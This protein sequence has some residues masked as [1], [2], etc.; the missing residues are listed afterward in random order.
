MSDGG[1]ALQTPPGVTLTSGNSF[2]AW[3][4][5]RAVEAVC[6]SRGFALATSRVAVVGAAGAIGHALTLL[7]SERIGQMILI[8]NPRAGE[9]SI[10]NLRAV[11]QDCERHVTSLSGKKGKFPTGILAQ[12]LIRRESAG[13][14][15]GSDPDPAM[16]VT[17]DLDQYLPTA[18]IIFTATS[19]VLP[20]I[21]SRHLRKDAI[22]CDVSR[23][24]NIASDLAQERPD[25]A[26]VLGGLVQAPKNSLLGLLEERDRPNI[27]MACA[28]ET[29]VLALSRYRSNHLCGRLDLA[30][31]EEM[32]RLAGRMGFSVAA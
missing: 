21:S 7:C 31:I 22:V 10:G 8:G 11:V 1:L 5:M 20:F 23:P 16:I 17:V 15:A 25:L 2:T 12:R 13:Q 14:M 30:T 3:V 18:D 19:A 24:F 27:L 9:A 26:I 28:A 6:A 4:A 32:A 29:I